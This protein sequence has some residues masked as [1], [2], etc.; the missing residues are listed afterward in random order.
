MHKITTMI[1]VA[2]RTHNIMIL[3]ELNQKHGV[4]LVLLDLSAAFDIDTINPGG[5]S[6]T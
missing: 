5:H 3:H 6:H 2:C 4:F 1:S